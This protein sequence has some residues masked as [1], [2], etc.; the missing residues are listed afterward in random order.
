MDPLF[1]NSVVLTQ[2]PQISGNLLP[3]V[4]LFNTTYMQPLAREPNGI[5]MKTQA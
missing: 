5:M 1:S 4:F 2:L 3:C